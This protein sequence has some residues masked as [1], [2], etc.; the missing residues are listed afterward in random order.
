MATQSYCLDE[1]QVTRLQ[2]CIEQLRGIPA[3]NG[4]PAK[5]AEELAKIASDLGFDSGCECVVG[6]PSLRELFR[7]EPFSALL[8]IIYLLGNLLCECERGP[9]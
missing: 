8:N 5:V 1:A 7:D 2:W 6:G 4:F 9:R 3:Q